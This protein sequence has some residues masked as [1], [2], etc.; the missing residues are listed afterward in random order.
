MGKINITVQVD[1]ELEDP[2]DEWANR[3]GISRQQIIDYVSGRYCTGRGPITLI[4]ESPLHGTPHFSNVRISSAEIDW[5]TTRIL[6]RR[7]KPKYI[8]NPREENDIRT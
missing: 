4:N 8:S 2:R 5:R 1:I 6:S 7:N 3:S